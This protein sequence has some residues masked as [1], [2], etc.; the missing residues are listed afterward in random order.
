MTAIKPALRGRELLLLVTPLVLGLIGMAAI[1]LVK[2]GEVTAAEVRP[3]LAMAVA[4]AAAHIIL[5]LAAPTSDQVLLPL[6]AMLTIIGLVAVQRFS[7][8]PALGTLG[9]ELPS[10]QIAWAV[11]GLSIMVVVVLWPG[12][13]RAL[14]VYRYLW[15]F[16]GLALVAATLVF[17]QGGG[18]VG[19]R[20]WIS[21]GPWRF[22]PS[23]VMKVLM[24]AFLASYL[25]E[26]REL[27]AASS[28]RLGR[29]RLPP[30]P[31]L[32]PLLFVWGLSLAVLVLQEDLGAA[33]LFFAIF[34]SMLYMATGRPSYVW[35]GLALFAIGAILAYV[36]FAHV[37]VRVSIWLNPW[38][39][40][41]GKGYQTIQGLLAIA[42]GGLFGVGLGYGH[43]GLIPAVHTDLVLAALGEETGIVVMLA[44][45][46]LYAILC[47]RGL[48]IALRAADGFHALL[49]AGLSVAL[50]VQTVLI[51]GGTLRLLP[52]TGITLPFISYGGSSLVTNFLIIGLLLR[53]SMERTTDE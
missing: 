18:G 37:Q 47:A 34:L 42:A 1:A 40:A 20:L 2:V 39:D 8:D 28:V 46:A 15:L 49:A 13:L 32:L 22:Q 31:Y 3:V 44:I 33:V 14:R 45:I 11:L 25:D 38:A 35:F 16:G 48:H 5:S 51:V 10:R 7:W 21:I 24:V 9:A 17:G 19:S 53:V 41:Q 36:L 29:L 30:L 50:G 26:R 43:P 23:E 12:L 6:A 4:L 27:L 52:L